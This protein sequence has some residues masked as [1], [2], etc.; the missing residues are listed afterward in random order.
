MSFIAEVIFSFEHWLE[1][2]WVIIF[3]AN[4]SNIVYCMNS[5]WCE[6]DILDHKKKDGNADK[7]V[8]DDVESLLF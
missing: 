6:S 5:S 4:V 1:E 2:A 3:N 7:M 8:K